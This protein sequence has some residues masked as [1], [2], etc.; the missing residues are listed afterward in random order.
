MNCSYC[1][2]PL[3]PGEVVCPNCGALTASIQKTEGEGVP[4]ADPPT[5]VMPRVQ[6]PGVQ[7]PAEP[8]PLVAP[9]PDPGPP[10]SARI[11]PSPTS[12]SVA[13]ATS[14]RRPTRRGMMLAGLGGAAVVLVLAIGAIAIGHLGRPGPD[15]AQALDADATA[16][17]MQSAASN[18]P[19]QDGQ[20]IGCEARELASQ[21]SGRWRLYRAEYGNR[22]GHDYLRLKLRRESNEG[23]AAAMTA[24]M[25]PTGEVAARYGIDGP[26]N[27]DAALVIAF[28]GP[29]G[30][31]GPWGANPGYRA[32]R[33][34]QVAKSGDATVVVVG[35]GGEGCF[36]LSETGWTEGGAAADIT[37]DIE[38]L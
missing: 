19:A 35:V 16:E 8:L 18:P 32:L 3:A 21:G 11:E 29:V 23:D 30:I 22:A 36:G 5:E 1:Q 27:A 34:F 25:L 28:R 24:E 13:A 33:S 9:P 37:F 31:G 10:Q 38:R 20:E 15:A 6:V 14:P 17:P 4:T 26:D 2:L 7:T 12:P